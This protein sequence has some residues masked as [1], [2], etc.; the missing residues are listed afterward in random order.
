MRKYDITTFLN[1]WKHKLILTGILLKKGFPLRLLLCDI[2]FDMI[3]KGTT[4]MH[5][6]GIAINKN[7][8]MGERCDIRQGVTIGT[9]YR[10]NPYGCTFIGNDVKFDVNCTVLGS[11]VIGD[12]AEIGAH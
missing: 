1:K 12:G 5:P 11:V 4:F 7:V 2:E 8:F 3:P 9:R 6:W 10:D